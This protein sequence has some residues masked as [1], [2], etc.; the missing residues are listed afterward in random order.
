MTTEKH[1]IVLKNISTLL[2]KLHTLPAAWRFSAMKTCLVHRGQISPA[3]AESLVIRTGVMYAR[4]TAG[5]LL[6]NVNII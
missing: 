1:A 4:A 3:A 5:T 2:V 6:H